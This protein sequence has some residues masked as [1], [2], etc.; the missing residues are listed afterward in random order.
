MEPS[1]P[2]IATNGTVD[3]PVL[4][5]PLQDGVPYVGVGA[6]GIM[7]R[8]HVDDVCSRCQDRG[9]VFGTWNWLAVIVSYEKTKILE[10]VSHSQSSWHT[11]LRHADLKPSA[12]I[13]EA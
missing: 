2:K 6:G 1:G 13:G 7:T 11:W 9:S 10:I 5:M 8:L 3:T 4:W 12:C